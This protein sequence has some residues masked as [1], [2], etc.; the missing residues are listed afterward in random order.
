MA[1]LAPMGRASDWLRDERRK[2]LGTSAAVCLGCGAGRRWFEEFEDEA[3]SPC[4]LCGGQML[5]RCAVCLAPL[6]SI[7]QVECEGCGAT[8]RPS[9][10]NGLKIRRPPR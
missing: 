6:V 7:F 5:R 10:V 3:A 4:E 2:V 1:S 9:V 8:L